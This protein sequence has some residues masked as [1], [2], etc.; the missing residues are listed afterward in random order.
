MQGSRVTDA[1]AALAIF[2]VAPVAIILIVGLLR[3][4]SVWIHLYRHKEEDHEGHLRD[5]DR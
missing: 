5:T 1:Q 2:V 4:Y 3:G